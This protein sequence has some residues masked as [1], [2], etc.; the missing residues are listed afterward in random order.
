[1]HNLF[2]LLQANPDATNAIAAVANASTAALALIVSVVAVIVSCVTLKHQR[3]HN[4][5]SVR[6]VPEVTVAD[7]EESLRVRVRNHGAGPLILRG[8]QVTD[9]SKD[10]PSLVE[11]MPELP[12]HL[13]WT[14]FVG[15]VTDRCLLAGGELTLLQF[16]G[17]AWDEEFGKSRDGVREALARLTVDVDFT[18][19]YGSAFNRYRKDLSWFGRRLAPAGRSTG[20]EDPKSANRGYDGKGRSADSE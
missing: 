17:A 16:D 18:D 13:P 8:I 9:G 11:W 2:A 6:P 10:R 14:N 3:Q 1:M 12:A 5:L 7:F 19:I 15:P 4:K 20:V